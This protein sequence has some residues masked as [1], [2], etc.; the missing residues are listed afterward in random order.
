MLPKPLPFK[1]PP[2]SES[3][4]KRLP[5]RKRMTIAAGF[6]CTDGIVL[7]ADTKEVYSNSGDHTYVHKLDMIDS[8]QCSGALAGAG[9]SYPVD[10]VTSKIKELFKLETYLTADECERALGSLMALIYQSKQMKA[11]PKS[12]PDELQASFLVALRPKAEG[13]ES[14]LFLINS[15][16][17]TR[18]REGVR[19]IGY[20]LMQQMADEMGR[21][22]LSVRQARGAALYLI[23]ETKRRTSDVGGLTHIYALLNSG[24]VLPERTW[25]QAARETLFD[26][27]REL[28]HHM[29]IAVSN[30]E[31]QPWDYREAMRTV[32][33]NARSIRGEFRRIERRYQQWERERDKDLLD[34]LF[35]RSASEKSEPGQ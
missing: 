11:Y 24:E 8:P 6:I 13:G 32:V 34:S 27:L 30:P 15:S 26:S 4:P 18:V 16:L 25:D 33:L 10:Y 1:V 20:G 12:Q 19:V 35:R 2:Y 3:K 28:H 23:Y 21:S 17:V 7:A 5:A 9:Y 31:L 22:H 14:C 29:V